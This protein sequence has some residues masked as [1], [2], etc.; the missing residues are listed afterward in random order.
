[1]DVGS[2]RMQKVIALGD[3]RLGLKHPRVES[4]AR[5]LPKSS[6]RYICSKI[7]T[8]APYDRVHQCFTIEASACL[9]MPRTKNWRS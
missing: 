9:N 2:S 3:K 8:L 6:S 1:M 5:H 4:G 7:L